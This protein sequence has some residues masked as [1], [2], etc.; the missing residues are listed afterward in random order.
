MK[1][2]NTIPHS[3]VVVTLPVQCAWCR[4]WRVDAVWTPTA[5]ANVTM[6]K[7]SHGICPKCVESFHATELKGAA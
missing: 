4:L 6:G 5:P 7:V 2:P 3:G 1:S